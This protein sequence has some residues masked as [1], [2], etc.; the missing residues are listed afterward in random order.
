M[1]LDRFP[2]EQGF[3]TDEGK[4]VHPLFYPV[5]NVLVFD[6][7]VSAEMIGKPKL[8]MVGGSSLS[9]ETLLAVIRKAEE[10]AIVVIAEWLLPTECPG[11]LRSNGKMG[12]GRWMVIHDFLD[13]T[14]KEV[15]EPFLGKERCWT[16]RFGTS[17]V[18]IHPKDNEGFTLDFEIVTV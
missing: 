13:N 9:S 14:V 2:L 18:R 6:E 17:E 1:P 12:L 8:I 11:K 3:A 10:G 5:H 7:K 16:Q 15:I 4:R